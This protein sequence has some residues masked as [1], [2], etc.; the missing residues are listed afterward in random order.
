LD[1][2]T[3]IRRELLAAAD[4]ERAPKMQA[5]MKSA[6]PFLGVGVPEVRRIARAAERQEPP[7]SLSELTA[8]VRNLWDAAEYREE[9]YAATALLATATARRLRSPELLPLLRE[10]I[11]DGAWWD[12]VDELARRVGELLQ[13]HRAEVTPILH[14]WARNENR[15]LRRVSIIAQL[16]ARDAVDEGLLT[17]AIE[18]NAADRDFFI[19]KAIG[20]AL[21]DHARGAPQWVQAFVATHELSSLSRREALKHL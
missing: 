6:L 9:R 7:A 12:H 14:E 18:A 3:G 20:W 17:Y 8:R 11:V 10:L 2:L 19:R 13:S 16:G 5:S 1:V 15:W 21:R 4:P